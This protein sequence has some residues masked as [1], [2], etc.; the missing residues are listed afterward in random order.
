MDVGVASVRDASICKPTRH[1]FKMTN[2]GPKGN[3]LLTFGSLLIRESESFGPRFWGDR[4][5]DSGVNILR[6]R[7][8]DPDLGTSTGRPLVAIQK[9]DACHPSYLP[10]PP[11]RNGNLNS[12]M[13]KCTFMTAEAG[14]RRGRNP[15]C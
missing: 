12:Q 14:T 13:E 3:G 9:S 11:R 8:V 10:S 15:E 7:A 1:E 6:E 4:T 2:W 5:F